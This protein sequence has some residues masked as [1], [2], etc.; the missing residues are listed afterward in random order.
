MSWKHHHHF[1]HVPLP[2]TKRR[3][4]SPEWTIL[5]HSIASFRERL[6]DFRSCCIVFIHIVW[7]CQKFSFYWENCCQW[8]KCCMS[9]TRSASY[10]VCF[11]VRSCCSAW[12]RQLKSA[13]IFALTNAK[14]KY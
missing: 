14:H 11:W 5:S 4:Q 9:L 1:W 10:W 2:R 6:L 12:S 8:I 7:G 13:Q 3:H